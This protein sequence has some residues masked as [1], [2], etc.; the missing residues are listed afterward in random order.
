M[1]GDGSIESFLRGIEVVHD[2]QG[3]GTSFFEGH[4]G[5]GPAVFTFV[6]RPAEAECGVTSMY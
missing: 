5:D 6:I 1:G 2:D 4:R 3:L